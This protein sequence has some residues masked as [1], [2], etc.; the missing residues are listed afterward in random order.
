MKALK[1][2][3]GDA[4]NRLYKP[5]PGIFQLKVLFQCLRNVLA[6]NS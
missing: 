4:E 1:K 5:Y 2:S 6:S 3:Y